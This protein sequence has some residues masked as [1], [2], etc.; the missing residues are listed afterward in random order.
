ME[1]ELV[2]DGWN[3]GNRTDVKSQQHFPSSQHSLGNP[4][5]KAEG[6]CGKTHQDE[7]SAFDLLCVL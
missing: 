4:W 2:T 6:D 7:F 5:T 1:D 3:R